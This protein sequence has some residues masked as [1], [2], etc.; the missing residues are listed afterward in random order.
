MLGDAI[1]SKNF[2]VGDSV[3]PWHQGAIKADEG[4]Q[5]SSDLLVDI[6]SQ[7]FRVSLVNVADVLVV[8]YIVDILEMANIASAYWHSISK[9]GGTF[10]AM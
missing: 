4:E 7:S 3:T 1:A 8:V 2:K 10:N 5:S 6:E 9:L